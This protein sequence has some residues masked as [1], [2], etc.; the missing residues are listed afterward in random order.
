MTSHDRLGRIMHAHKDHDRSRYRGEFAMKSEAPRVAIITSG[1]SG[2]RLMCRTGGFA[3]L[4][5]LIAFAAVPAAAQ[6]QYPS[7][8]VRIIVGVVPG[9]SADA[10]G[11]IVAQ[12]LTER[13]KQNVIV[14]NRPGA[15]FL[16]AL[17]LLMNS[18]P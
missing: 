5:M 7:R 9:G 15:N 1:G 10:M 16:I 2:R 18:S 11:R 17:Q 14:D 12:I 4:A 6:Q 13:F 8:P 3:L